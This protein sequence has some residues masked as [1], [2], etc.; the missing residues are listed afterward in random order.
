MEDGFEY[1]VPLMHRVVTFIPVE[2]FEWFTV[3]LDLDGIR[4]GVIS[5]RSLDHVDIFL[6]VSP[7]LLE[8]FIQFSGRQCCFT[9]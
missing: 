1:D 4:V 8:T 6:E 9:R 7:H 2:L 3:L 5:V